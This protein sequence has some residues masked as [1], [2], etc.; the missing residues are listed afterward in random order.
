MGDAADPVLGGQ[1]PRGAFDITGLVEKTLLYAPIRRA[2]HLR[3]F[4]SGRDQL[5]DEFRARR[6]ATRKQCECAGEQLLVFRFWR[7]DQECFRMN[8]QPRLWQCVHTM[9]PCQ[10]VPVQALQ[11]CHSLPASALVS[12][13]AQTM[14]W[15]TRSQG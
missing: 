14:P 11:V 9:P 2:F 7:I 1:P 8:R 4:V 13:P 6:I 3:L 10:P 12:T 5:G 15:L